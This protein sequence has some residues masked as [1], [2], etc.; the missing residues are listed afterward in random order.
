MRVPKT[1]YNNLALL[2]KQVCD[3]D[4]SKEIIIA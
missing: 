1:I 4:V 3:L 2:M